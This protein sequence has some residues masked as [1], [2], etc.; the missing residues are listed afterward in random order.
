MLNK[1]MKAYDEGTPKQ[2]APKN[3]Y[4]VRSA[5]EMSGCVLGPRH[6]VVSPEGLASGGWKCALV[7]V[8]LQG[9]ASARLAWVDSQF[10]HAVQSAE[11]AEHS[12]DG[13]AHL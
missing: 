9:S 1:D 8:P 3:P 12:G 10:R 4:E 13:R 2:G 11:N 5:P 6:S 7:G